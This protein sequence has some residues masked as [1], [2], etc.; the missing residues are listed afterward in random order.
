MPELP[1]VETVARGVDARV[2]GERIVGGVVWGEE[3]AVEVSGSGDGAGADGGADCGG[4][5]GG[6]DDRV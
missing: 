2:R 6:E 5:A 4:A 1:E 3:G